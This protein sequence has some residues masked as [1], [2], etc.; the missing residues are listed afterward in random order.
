M[1]NRAA[2]PF[3]AARAAI[4]RPAA[5][6]TPACACPTAG[7]PRRRQ[8][9]TCSAAKHRRPAD[10]RGHGHN[11]PAGTQRDGAGAR[12]FGQ[13]ADSQG[14]ASLAAA[15]KAVDESRADARAAVANFRNTLL[16]RYVDWSILRVAPKTEAGSPTPGASCASSPTGLSPRCCAARPRSAS[17]RRRRRRRSSAT[18][19][20]FHRSPA[21]AT[22][23]AWRRPRPQAPTTSRSSRATAGA[24]PP[25]ATPTRTSS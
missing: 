16:D 12:R 23:A 15:L 5:R 9:Q 21:P 13:A 20:P 4:S 6:P 7:R 25:S 14:G 2:S 10:R 17:D 24:A 19:R 18:S 8:P 1:P 11:P 3:C 22:C